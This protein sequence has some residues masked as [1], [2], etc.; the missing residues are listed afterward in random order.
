M[1]PNPQPASW[2]RGLYFLVIG[3][4]ILGFTWWAI[5]LYIK[6]RDAFQAKV[7]LLRMGMESEGLYRNEEWFER[8]DAYLSLKKKYASQEWMIYGESAVFVFTIVAGVWLINRGYH[9]E[10]LAARQRRNFLHSITHELKSPLAS[11]R[12]VLETLLKR[13][14]PAEQVQIFGNRALRETERLNQ[15][16]NDLLLSARLDVAYQPSFEKVN[17]T[18]MVREILEAISEKHPESEIR[19]DLG[20]DISIWRGDRNGLQ[21]VVQ[22]L[23]ENAVK[24][25]DGPPAIEIRLREEN[26]KIFL[27][28]ADQGIGI[29]DK[30]KK[31]IFE[32]FYR[33]GTEDTRKTKGTGLGLFIVRQVVLAHGGRVTVGNNKPKGAVFTI[34]LF[35]KPRP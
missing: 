12:L 16:V 33:V 23:V 21:S 2:W 20:R 11:I 18:E 9:K 13:Q 30:E 19:T 14:L 7:E 31:L 1:R 28:V 6:N 34:E 3:Y 35:N 22:N 10:M 25:S 27:S 4:L 26:Q 32:K 24:Y 5:L 8:T 17:L 29:D 15:L